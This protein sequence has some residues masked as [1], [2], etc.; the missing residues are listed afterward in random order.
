[1]LRDLPP[2][3]LAAARYAIAAMLAGGGWHGRPPVPARGDWPRIL[4]ACGAI[5]IALVTISCSTPA[6]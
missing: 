1:V 6:K 5:G 3:P 2:V 4:E